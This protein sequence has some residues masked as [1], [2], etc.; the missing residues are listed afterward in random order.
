MLSRNLLYT[1]NLA[2]GSDQYIRITCE[3]DDTGNP[4][5]YSMACDFKNQEIIDESLESSVIYSITGGYWITSNTLRWYIT[6]YKCK[7][8]RVEFSALA[9]FEVPCLIA[10]SNLYNADTITNI[11]GQ[12]LNLLINDIEVQNFNNI[13][14]ISTLLDATLSITEAEFNGFTKLVNTTVGSPSAFNNF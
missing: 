2:L 6:N 13:I 14:T 4:I 7:D 3:L 11:Q 8:D 9:L 5:Q 1:Y 10:L 12:I